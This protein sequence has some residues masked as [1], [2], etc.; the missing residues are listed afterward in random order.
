M[1]AIYQALFGAHHLSS[2]S[3]GSES[4]SGDVPIL[5][6][7]KPTHKGVGFLAQAH[8]ANER[9]WLQSPQLLTPFC[10]SVP[11]LSTQLS[12]A[13]LSPL[14]SQ[15]RMGPCPSLTACPTAP[16]PPPLTL[17][18]RTLL[19]LVSSPLPSPHPPRSAAQ[20]GTDSNSGLKDSLF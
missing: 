10:F 3:C 15:P 6:M 14:T 11:H 12:P 16:F 7:R 18:F 5:Q 1:V 8:S 9:S 20:Q 2:F 19:T 4:G 13:Q 17:S